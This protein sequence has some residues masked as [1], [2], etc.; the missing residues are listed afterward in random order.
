MKTLRF[1]ALSILVPAI[2]AAAEFQWRVGLQPQ[3]LTESG[4]T[5]LWIRNNGT[6]AIDESS[7]YGD[8]RTFWNGDTGERIAGEHYDPRAPRLLDLASD[9]QRALSTARDGQ[10]HIGSAKLGGRREAVKGVERVQQA[11]FL[12]GDDM[13]VAIGGSQGS[14][15]LYGI[16]TT[17]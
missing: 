2:A 5:S 9:G 7:G 8:L 4:V 12:P 10:L 17:A 14:D 6:V 11:R 13:A 16:S 15:K 3:P 1:F